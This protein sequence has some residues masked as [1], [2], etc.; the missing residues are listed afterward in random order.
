MLATHGIKVRDFAY[1]SKLPP[2]PSY[3][4]P[5][6]AGPRRLKRTR[7]EYEAGDCE[8]DDEQLLQALARYSLHPKFRAELRPSKR[9]R[10]LERVN[11]EPVE[12]SQGQPS[13][14]FS[15]ISEITDTYTEPSNS[16]PRTYGCASP[17]V[18]P[19][20]TPVSLP[21]SPFDPIQSPRVLR[22]T[23]PHPTV[24]TEMLS[25]DDEPWVDTPKVSPDDSLDFPFPRGNNLPTP[26]I[27]SPARSPFATS[28]TFTGISFTPS[29][30]QRTHTPLRRSLSRNV[31]QLGAPPR[32]SRSP[33]LHQLPTAKSRPRA[34][35]VPHRLSNG[36]MQPAPQPRYHLRDRSRIARTSSSLTVSRSRSNSRAAS[37]SSTHRSDG[38]PRSSLSKGAANAG[39]AKVAPKPK[40]TP[41]LRRSARNT[42]R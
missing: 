27:Q 16:Q 35:P 39:K 13:T 9:V 12:E 6:I 41:A 33:S 11:T 24:D 17:P 19:R 7:A 22:S 42:G 23:S 36:S 37:S 29:Q 15:N 2:V 28:V 10:V 25:H 8:E 14:G 1:E 3:K 5:I 30:S 32:L 26:R 18:T 34:N 31:L 20:P 4:R 40:S 21:R 38:K